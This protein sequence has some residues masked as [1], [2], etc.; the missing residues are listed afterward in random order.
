MYWEKKSILENQKDAMESEK[1]KYFRKN[2]YTN[3]FETDGVA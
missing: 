1:V 2:W 3:Y